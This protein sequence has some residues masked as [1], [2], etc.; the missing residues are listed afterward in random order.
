MKFPWNGGHF[1]DGLLSFS[2]SRERISR[3]GRAVIIVAREK[4]STEFEIFIF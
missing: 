2:A 1:F 4:V 3:E